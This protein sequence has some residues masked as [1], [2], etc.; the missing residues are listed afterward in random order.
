MVISLDLTT[1]PHVSDSEPERESAR[2]SSSAP[3]Q[4]QRLASLAS[5]Q[6]SHAVHENSV[7][8]ASPSRVHPSNS[9]SLLQSRRGKSNV[10][11]TQ[12]ARD[13][14]EDIYELPARID[15]R[16]E[17]S[18]SV[19]RESSAS[20]PPPGQ[21]QYQSMNSPQ[22]VPMVQDLSSS[23]SSASE[24]MLAQEEDQAEEGQNSPRTMFG[25]YLQ[26]RFA[27]KP[28]PSTSPR[29]AVYHF[30]SDSAPATAASTTTTTS[31]RK[32]K[33]QDEASTDNQKLKRSQSKR[34]K[35]ADFD[36]ATTQVLPLSVMGVLTSCPVC[37]TSWTAKKSPAVKLGHTLECAKAREYELDTVRALV[38]K[39]VRQLRQTEASEATKASE[40]ETV[41][42]TLFGEVVKGAS[43]GVMRG[44]KKAVAVELVGIDEGAIASTQGGTVHQNASGTQIAK[45]L[46]RVKKAKPAAAKRTDTKLGKAV[47]LLDASKASVQTPPNPKSSKSTSQLQPYAQ[48]KERLANKAQAMFAASSPSPAL[49]AAGVSVA[50]VSARNKGHKSTA[51]ASGQFTL[52]N[53]DAAIAQPP[54]AS[55]SS[56]KQPRRVISL[57]SDDE[58]H[59]GEGGSS[60]YRTC[61]LGTL[62]ELGCAIF[63]KCQWRGTALNTTASAFFVGRVCLW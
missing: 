38:E 17:S 41:D 40:K 44:G 18:R 46:D 63:R 11:T 34:V 29:P 4:Q 2:E 57:D 51:P 28:R 9:S 56:F 26:A 6:S 33:V 48:T 27:Y 62:A 19:S 31:R 12:E 39:Q 58:A 25:Q 53:F 43:K 50:D 23:P 61:N 59:E 8:R 13:E 32:D 30:K 45:E 36:I 35:A 20:P 7:M 42:K 10:V 5:T 14:D 22:R 37:K 16:G 47:K 15:I 3:P 55:T 54:I 49:P 24:S 52:Q 60:R 1:S 21:Q